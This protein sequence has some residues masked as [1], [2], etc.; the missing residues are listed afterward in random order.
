MYGSI[1]FES[2]LRADQKMRENF[3]TISSMDITQEEKQQ[4]YHER[5]Q[6]FMDSRLEYFDDVVK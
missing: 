2:V 4:K 3:K 6:A 1:Q 5:Y